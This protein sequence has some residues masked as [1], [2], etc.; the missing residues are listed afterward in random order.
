MRSSLRSG[1]HSGSLNDTEM[2]VGSGWDTSS[3]IRPDLEG[4][5]EDIT[6]VRAKGASPT[7]SAHGYYA[8]VVGTSD[9][10]DGS[11]V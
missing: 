8:H 3:T 11:I 2:S 5:L 1:N 6:E 7:I 10:V 9:S 4:G